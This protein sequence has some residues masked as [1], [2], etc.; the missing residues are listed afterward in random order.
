MNL[1]TSSVPSKLIQ[2]I[3]LG[4]NA[5]LLIGVLAIG[6]LYNQVNRDLDT[7]KSTVAVLQTELAKEVSRAA[8][9][10]SDLNST[11]ATA[12]SLAEKSTQL[13][14]AIAMNQTALAQEKIKAEAAQT[15]LEQEKARLP[16][17]PVRVEM[18]R[19]A[20]GR[21]LVA[22]LSNTSAKQLP[23]I[24]ATQ[25]PTTRNAR[26]FTIQIAPGSKVEIGHQ[27]GWEFASGDRVLLVSSGFEDLR[28]LVP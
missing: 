2:N 5:I 28:Y 17:V 7:Q 1:E 16:V 21:G 6:F 12:Q 13:Q 24:V 23:V 10:K 3:S 27:E 14:A 9:L 25:N 18:R 22:V 15:A 8:E 20:M 11:R 19:S 4:I 26:R